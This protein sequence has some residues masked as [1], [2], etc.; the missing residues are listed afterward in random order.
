MRPV[1]IRLTIDYIGTAYAGWQ[2]QPR[3]ITVQG[4]LEAALE[5]LTG[6]AV[7]VT[8]SGRTDAGV[9]ALGQV[10]HFDLETDWPVSA[11]MGGLNRYLPH[12]IRVLEAELAPAGFHARFSAK[13]KTYV[14]RMYRSDVERAVYCGRA[15]RVD[16]AIDA[17]AMRVAAQ[18]FLG[19]Q[20]F[21]SLCASHADTKSC[22]RTV[23][24]ADVF[25]EENEIY[26]R[27]CAD[28]F[29]YNMVRIMTGLLL[30]AGRGE[31]TPDDVRDVLQA[32]DRTLARDT[33][34]ACGL[35]LLCVNYEN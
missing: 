12:D 28:G 20:D 33:A 35:Y 2:V 26:F 18:R 8:G 23:Y 13:R 9:H 34:P 10:A 31:M 24:E 14:Y 1:R 4:E 25:A 7:R 30:R 19:T 16:P 6:T 29:L 5:K 3:K 17:E 21:S 32:C 11:F 27:V 22:V 15:L